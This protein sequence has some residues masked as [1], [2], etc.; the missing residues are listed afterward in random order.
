M[1][2]SIRCFLGKDQMT[3]SECD[4]TVTS[5]VLLGG[6]L[7]VNLVLNLSFHSLPDR[8]L[9]KVDLQ[10][11]QICQF[12]STNLWQKVHLVSLSV[13][14]VCGMF[15][16]GNIGVEA[17]DNFD[18]NYA[19]NLVLVGSIGVAGLICDLFARAY[20]TR[21]EMMA[22]SD[23]EEASVKPI[24]A[25]SRYFSALAFLLISLNCT[26][27]YVGNRS[28]KTMYEISTPIT[29]FIFIISNAMRPRDNSKQYMLSLHAQFLLISCVRNSQILLTGTDDENSEAINIVLGTKGYVTCFIVFVWWVHIYAACLYTRKRLAALSD[30]G[31]EKFFTKTMMKQLGNRTSILFFFAFKPIRCLQSTSVGIDSTSVCGPSI[32]VQLSLSYMFIIYSLKE[33]TEMAFPLEVQKLNSVPMERVATLNIP[34]RTHIEGVLLAIMGSSGIFCFANFNATT[35]GLPLLVIGVAGVAAIL[36]VF[37][38]KLATLVRTNS[39]SSDNNGTSPSNEGVEKY[40]VHQLASPYVVVSVFVTCLYSA[41]YLA[42]AITLDKRCWPIANQILPLSIYKFCV[43]LCMRPKDNSE[44]YRRFLHAHFCQFALLTEVLAAIGHARM[45]SWLLVTFCG[46][47]FVLWIFSWRIFVGFRSL[48][49]KLE[50][51]HMSEYL[52]NTV[53]SRSTVLVCPCFFFIMETATCMLEHPNDFIVCQNSS[54][55]SLYLSVMVN[56][57]VIWELLIKAVPPNSRHKVVTT[58][59]DLA[60]L[61]LGKKRRFQLSLVAFGG[62]SGLF[63]SPG[64]GLSGESHRVWFLVGSSG[65]LCTLVSTAIDGVTVIRTLRKRETIQQ[66]EER[67]CHPPELHS[68]KTMSTRMLQGGGVMDMA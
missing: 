37:L 65:A 19:S 10:T 68:H 34:L 57:L 22:N 30:D 38:M 54:N 1:F 60:T 28:L 23:Q 36:A 63:L 32:F 20:G 15:L 67:S 61:R 18:E 66:H 8:L 59:K 35:R 43:S 46:V 7:A 29:N 5:Q 4:Q 40:L 51:E 49:T 26:M 55:S 14:V 53:L 47:R 9:K 21:Q 31:L 12:G 48:F 64:L 16:L 25:L 24:D 11:R 56:C 33:V 17:K 58:L 44:T 3:Y 13:T 42:F 50:N 39:A 62:V 6:C 52:V 2:D 45:S 27:P 41:C